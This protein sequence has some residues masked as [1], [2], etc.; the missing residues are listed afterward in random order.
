MTEISSFDPLDPAS[1][2][3]LRSWWEVGRDAYAERPYDFWTTWDE[4]SRGWTI[5]P[6]EREMHYLLARDPAGD[7]VGAA[8]VV[9]PTKDND[10]LA[11]VEVFVSSAGATPGRRAGPAGRGRADRPSPAVARSLSSTSSP[12]PSEQNAG[13][14]F[15]AAAGYDHVATEVVK[16]CEI[17]A[18]E[19]T[20]PALADRAAERASDYR[21][22]SWGDETPEEH[23]ADICALYTAFL[24]EIPL[25]GMDIK[26]QQ[27]TAERL[28]A[29]EERRRKAGLRAAHRGCRGTRRHGWRATPT[30]CGAPPRAGLHRR[31]PGAPRTPRALAG[32]GDEGPAAPAG[33]R[34]LPRGRDH[35]DRQRRRQRPHERRQRDARLPRGRAHASSMQKQLALARVVRTDSQF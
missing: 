28:R 1:L 17:A 5:P 14:A 12:R 24:G 4:A 6:I 13:T 7:A 31:H 25:E 30:S 32:A 21:L 34:D 29:T 9:L 20:W 11:F 16:V 26:P 23:V 8:R 18:T 10:H 33:A 15:A 19:S 35:R 27:W 2:P 22:V 3:L